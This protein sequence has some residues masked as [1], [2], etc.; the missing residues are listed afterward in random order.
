MLFRITGICSDGVEVLGA[1]SILEIRIVE[2]FTPFY[3]YAMAFVFG[4]GLAVG[5]TEYAQ[6]DVG[7]GR[8]QRVRFE[9]QAAAAVVCDTGA[10]RRAWI[11]SF[12]HRTGR[13]VDA[14]VFS[15]VPIADK[16]VHLLFRHIKLRL[17]FHHKFCPLLCI[18]GF[19]IQIRQFSE[20]RWSFL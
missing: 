15:L 3:L 13:V 5:R 9:I 2:I 11:E 18:S 12:D 14:V 17:F 19:E 20:T 8:N 1:V 7:A 6:V 10:N 16:G 4:R